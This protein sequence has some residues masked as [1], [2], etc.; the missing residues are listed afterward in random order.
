MTRSRPSA[1]RPKRREIMSRCD[2]VSASHP[3]DS[4]AGRRLALVSKRSKEYGKV[5]SISSPIPGRAWRRCDGREGALQSGASAGE[6]SRRVRPSSC[7]SSA[8]SAGGAESAADRAI[9]RASA[10]VGAGASRSA[11]AASAGT[12]GG[13]V[14]KGKARTACRERVRCDGG[15]DG[16]L[17]GGLGGGVGMV[18]AMTVIRPAA[19]PLAPCTSARR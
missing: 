13:P 1:T 17:G 11:P 3:P 16:G 6:P 9:G 12:A 4:G 14:R 10:A 19:S 15:L 5:R 2:A 18:S 8:R 7:A